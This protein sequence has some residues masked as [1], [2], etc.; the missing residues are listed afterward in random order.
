V[1]RELHESSS[2]GR[3]VAGGGLC[4][5][6]SSRIVEFAALSRERLPEQSILNIVQLTLDPT[7]PDAPIVESIENDERQVAASSF[8]P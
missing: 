5:P 1:N 4:H 8:A 2:S 6:S 3:R 7:V